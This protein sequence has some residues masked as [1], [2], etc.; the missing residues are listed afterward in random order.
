MTTSYRVLAVLLCLNARGP[1]MA[2]DACDR[3][4]PTSLRALLARRF[5]GYRVP[6]E[7]DTHGPCVQDRERTSENR[8][9]LATRG[10]FDGDGEQDVAVVMPSQTASAPPALVVALR[11][12]HGWKIERLTVGTDATVHHFVISTLHPGVYRETAAVR[13]ENEP[14]RVVRSQHD[15]V[16]I[17]ACDVWS[18]GHFRVDS[19]WQSISLSD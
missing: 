14:E 18:D 19:K 3:V 17:S 15:G 13:G 8:C 6:R 9:V 10:D 11:R 4:V 2:S 5:P 16:A 12:R 7:V 1:M